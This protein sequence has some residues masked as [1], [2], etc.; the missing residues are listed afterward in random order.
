M[1]KLFTHRRRQP[2]RPRGQRW[3]PR[4]WRQICRDCWRRGGRRGRRPCEVWR[5]GDNCVP[6]LDGV[7]FDPLPSQG[8]DGSGGA[9]RELFVHRHSVLDSR[10]RQHSFV[11]VVFEI[12]FACQNV[13]LGVKRPW[14]WT[15]GLEKI[16]NLGLILFNIVYNFHSIIRLSFS[17]KKYWIFSMYLLLI[18]QSL[19]TDLKWQ[20]RPNGWSDERNISDYHSGYYLWQSGA[21]VFF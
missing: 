7:D 8:L 15:Y 4:S 21:N 11:L 3:S 18:M 14:P 17:F 9:E 16:G 1:V 2:S 20:L 13:Y 10:L 19:N 6:L 5:R 12:H